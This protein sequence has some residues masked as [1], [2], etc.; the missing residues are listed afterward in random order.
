LS[1]R[2]EKANAI[3]KRY[4]Y[5][6]AGFGLIPVPIVDIAVITGTQ[7]KMVSALAK[8]Y[9][10]EFKEEMVRASIG[11]LVGG[12][13]PVAIG[14]GTVSALKTV[15]VLGQ[16]AGTLLLP[17]LALAS[18]V[19][20]GRVFLQHFEAGGTL[21]DFDPE[22]MK[23]YFEAEFNKAKAGADSEMANAS[24]EGKIAASA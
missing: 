21:L 19:A 11:A 2:I 3:I 17:A 8:L 22:K 15:P 10:K 12:T 20:V 14:G 13:L 23:S 1:E 18:T 5:W 6:S 16:I 9:D 7:I 4:S 24:S